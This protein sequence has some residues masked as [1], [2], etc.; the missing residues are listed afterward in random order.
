M[1]HKLTVSALAG[2]ALIMGACSSDESLLAEQNVSQRGDD[3]YAAFSVSFNSTGSRDITADVNADPLEQQIN[4]L[5][6]YIFSGGMLEVA[7]QTQVDENN[8]TKAIAVTTG[9]KVVYAV[10]GTPAFA[11]G[12]TPEV[13]KTLQS[14]FEEALFESLSKDIASV[15]E[16]GGEKNGNFIM[17]G[18][19]EADVVKRTQEEAKANPVK[20]ALDRAAAKVQVTYDTAEGA[21][22]I[23][24]TINA[25]FSQPK[26]G[27]GQQARRMYVNLGNRFTFLGTPAEDNATGTYPGLVPLVQDELVLIDAPATSQ[28]YFANNLYTAENVAEA[29]TTGNVTFALVRLTCTP[30]KV[31]N[32]GALTDGTFY[33]AALNNPATATWL[34]AADEDY[35]NIYF[36]TKEEAESY[37]AAKSLTNYKAYEYTNGNAY[38]RVNIVHDKNIAVDESNGV[39]EA[40][41]LSAK[42]RVVRNN[43]YRINV[44]AV[45]ALGAPTGPGVVPV[46]PTTPIEQ[47]SW[48]A[49]EIDVNAWLTIDRDVELQ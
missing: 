7:E 22:E 15:T 29:P 14:A 46:D 13:D 23:R 44:T 26:F 38:Y 41:Y 39:T 36:A 6:I 10:A 43:Y 4:T 28:K 47:D 42:Y 25:G 48:I 40:A 18:R 30:K 27:L 49:A 17:S 11:N 31:Y 5:N 34:F 20:I 19:E 12:F 32:D 1:N 16:T 24:S 37:I 3:T 8:K 9:R 21:V 33:V 45:T 35:N 2:L